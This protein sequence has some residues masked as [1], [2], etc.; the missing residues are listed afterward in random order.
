MERVWT[1]IGAHNKLKRRSIGGGVLPRNAPYYVDVL[2]NK[3]TLPI[4]K[5]GSKRHRKQVGHNM[6]DVGERVVYCHSTNTGSRLTKGGVGGCPAGQ[7][8]RLPGFIPEIRIEGFEAGA[9]G[10]YR[11]AFFLKFVFWN[12]GWC[13]KCAS[14]SYSSCI[15]VRRSH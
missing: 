10:T 11:L 12:V 7:E 8:R 2:G 14:L 6:Q 15:S 9:G 3:P 5:G 13:L 1:Y 4:I